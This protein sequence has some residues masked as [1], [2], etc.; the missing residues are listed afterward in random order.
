MI[1]DVP[2]DPF[3]GD[4]EDPAKLFALSEDPA[5][6]DPPLT[7][8]E[9]AN[10]AEEMSDLEI[11]RAVL[12][13]QGVRGLVVDCTGCDESHYYDWEL[14]LSNLMLMIDAGRLG[15]HEPAFRPD[16]DFYVTWDYARGFADAVLADAEE[17]DSHSG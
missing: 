10:L 8:Q 15:V 11:F 16:P 6:Q 5:A 12:E 17:E 7:M 13:P 4:P 14:L 3:E 1:S 9:R 2:V